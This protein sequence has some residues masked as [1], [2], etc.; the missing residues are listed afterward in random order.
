MRQRIQALYHKTAFV[1]L[2]ARA[3]L[4]EARCP[5]C[6]FTGGDFDLTVRCDKHHEKLFLMDGKAYHHYD[7][8][9]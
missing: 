2:V 4:I 8:V 6:E 5:N 7:Q 9:H 3:F 1:V